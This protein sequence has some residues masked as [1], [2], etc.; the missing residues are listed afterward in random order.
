MANAIRHSS[1]S[2]SARYSFSSFGSALPSLS[3]C[4]TCRAVLPK[5]SAIC[6]GVWP[7]SA[8]L[9]KASNSS[10]GCIASRTVLSA[11]LISRASCSL[12]DLAGH[13]VIGG[14]LPFRLQGFQRLQAAAAVDDAV[15]AVF[16]GGD[17]Q[18]VQDAVGED[19][20][21]QLLRRS[22]GDG[23]PGVLRRLFELVD[24]NQ[25]VL[26]K[27]ISISVKIEKIRGGL[28]P[29]PVFS[30]VLRHQDG[31][32][33][34]VGFG[35][36]PE[37][38]ARRCRRPTTAGRLPSGKLVFACDLRGRPRPSRPRRGGV[39]LRSPPTASSRSAALA[40]MTICP[41]G[42]FVVG[43]ARRA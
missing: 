35:D 26:H 32:D 21:F 9:A 8:S 34:A 14:Q 11:R 1:V 38:F 20:G 27:L 30:V 43:M 29:A 7:A 23:S 28:P 3:R 6:S 36:D 17:D 25:L 31:R 42:N 4:S 15:D 24:F 18:V 12:A 5:R 40:V 19:R 37:P 22:L 10:A 13:G 16:A 33:R 39:S 41:S 2:F